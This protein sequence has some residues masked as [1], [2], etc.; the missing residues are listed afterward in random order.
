[1]RGQRTVKLIQAKASVRKTKFD[2]E[3]WE[4]VDRGLFEELRRLRREIA[5]GRGVP[6]YV[7]FSDA[8]LRDLARLR[9]GSP[10]TMRTVRGVGERKLV[11]LGDRFLGLIAQFCR[12]NGLQLN[13]IT[14]P[15]RRSERSARQ[16]E[17]KDQAFKMFANGARVEDVATATGRAMSTAW[18]YLVEFVESHPSQSLDPWMDKGTYDAVIDATQDVGT[19]YL[20][21][22]HEKLGGKVSFEH[23]RLALA[24]SRSSLDSHPNYS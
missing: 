7:L 6:P 8:T 13:E 11:D 9:P 23:I 19:A 24:R 16:N 22:I 15:P 5:D 18:V 12:T 20:R 3:S 17:A 14:A 4:G 2:E 10:A 21:P 1:M